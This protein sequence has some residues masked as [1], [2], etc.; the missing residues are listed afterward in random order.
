MKHKKSK[1]KIRFANDDWSYSFDELKEK[2]GGLRERLL[3]AY[4]QVNTL[5][6]GGALGDDMAV[7]HARKAIEKYKKALE[8][9]EKLIRQRKS[10][11]A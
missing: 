6:K 7:E 8:E 10:G 5:R 4:Q 9:V 2:E 3:E 11:T 1:I